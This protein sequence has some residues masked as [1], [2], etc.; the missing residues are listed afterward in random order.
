MTRPIHSA[1]G[2]RKPL[3]PAVR[4]V[5]LRGAATD[6]VH[7]RA[8]MQPAHGR[9]GAPKRVRPSRDARR[10]AR[11]ALRSGAACACVAWLR[12]LRARCAA[13]C[14]ARLRRQHR[15][16]PCRRARRHGRRAARAAAVH[17]GYSGGGGAGAA[18]GVPAA[19]CGRGAGGVCAC[20]RAGLT[21]RTTHARRAR[22]AHA[23]RAAATPLL[24]SVP[25][26]ACR[27]RIVT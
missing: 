19:G 11:P 16:R 12:P 7:R 25:P 2:T 26:L 6:F 13:A 9:R 5:G 21:E 14:L 18:G 24:T 22:S 23:P 15:L 4:R 1:C 10:A 20:W 8:S 3:H 17:A 27:R